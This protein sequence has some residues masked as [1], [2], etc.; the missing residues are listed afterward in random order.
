MPAEASQ[1]QSSFIGT[2]IAVYEVLDH[3]APGEE[4]DDDAAPRRRGSSSRLSWSRQRPRQ[5]RALE[6]A[7]PRVRAT[8]GGFTRSKG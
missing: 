4:I 8:T 6:D 5:A 1:R 2:R 3:M 7:R